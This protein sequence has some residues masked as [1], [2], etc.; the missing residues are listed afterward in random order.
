MLKIADYRKLIIGH[1]KEYIIGY[2]ILTYLIVAFVVVNIAYSLTSYT[3]LFML[4]FCIFIV[5]PVSLYTTIEYLRYKRHCL[6]YDIAYDLWRKADKTCYEYHMS[7]ISQLFMATPEQ[8]K[9]LNRLEHRAEV[10]SNLTTRALH[11]KLSPREIQAL[12]SRPR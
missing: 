1:L 9:K 3:Y 4:V 10:L 11:D 12:L 6:L 2:A 7:M 8:Y 5:G